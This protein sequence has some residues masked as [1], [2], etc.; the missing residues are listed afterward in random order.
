MNRFPFSRLRE[1]VPEADEGMLVR[2]N[3]ERP[4][5]TL[6]RKREREKKG[7]EDQSGAELH[8]IVGL[9]RRIAVVEPLVAPAVDA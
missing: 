2:A 3:R 5:P 7:S 8:L 9:L 1:K 6:S 4:H